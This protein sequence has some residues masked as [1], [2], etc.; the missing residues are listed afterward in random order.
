[1]VAANGGDGLSHTE[2]G[3]DASTTSNT[4]GH[5]C[6]WGDDDDGCCDS[7]DRPWT[8]KDDAAA[9]VET[10][11]TEAAE[12]AGAGAGASTIQPN[13]TIRH[14]LG[15]SRAVVSIEGSVYRLRMRL[16]WTAGDHEQLECALA[17]LPI[18]EWG[19]AVQLV[20]WS[21]PR[22]MGSARFDVP[23]VSPNSLL[24]LHLVHCDL[25]NL[26]MLNELRHLESLRIT[27]CRVRDV[28]A[29]EWK[30]CLANLTSLSTLCLEALELDNATLHSI[31]TNIGHVT[32]R[33]SIGPLYNPR[34]FFPSLPTVVQECRCHTLEL[35][36]GGRKDSNL[37]H[38][39]N[40]LGRSMR[41]QSADNAGNKVRNMVVENFA[42]S[43]GLFAKLIRR[44]HHH[45]SSE[46]GLRHF[47][48]ALP[49][50]D[51]SAAS[52]PPTM[53][54]LPVVALLQS[55][56]HLRGLHLDP[57]VQVDT[58]WR[59]PL[60]RAVQRNT[61]LIELTGL[62]LLESNDVKRCDPAAK[63]LPQQ[64]GQRA[65]EAQW[66]EE[67]A[68]W[69]ELNRCGRR[70]LDLPIVRSN[71][72][73]WPHVLQNVLEVSNDPNVVLYFLKAGSNYH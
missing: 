69:L 29:R 17:T 51:A 24:E 63:T 71:P 53:H 11:D 45:S 21:L 19:G 14:Q 64:R 6:W 39:V 62:A 15:D 9:P 42:C 1:M 46:H 3:D 60:L 8:C 66:R 7:D 68:F 50:D 27:D 10:T 54:L 73:L 57:P 32:N 33:I 49:R 37:V 72:A 55:D 59:T 31:A 58:K 36:G 65:N 40:G 48:F 70:A 22:L 26:S 16:P 56:T 52:Q 25:P 18:N 44:L 12:A 43:K 67:I 20:G 38:V 13:I 47:T 30:T 4:G 23:S 2:D 35:F 41:L 61:H 5:L 34:Q 28:P